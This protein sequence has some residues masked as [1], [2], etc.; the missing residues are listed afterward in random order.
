MFFFLKNIKKLQNSYKMNNKRFNF[1]K[2]KN[3]YGSVRASFDDK[4]F[5]LLILTYVCNRESSYISNTGL[6]S[7]FIW[8]QFSHRICGIFFDIW[9]QDMQIPSVWYD[10]EK[11]MTND[12]SS[13]SEVCE[14]YELS[15]FIQHVFHAVIMSN[16]NALT[17][18]IRKLDNRTG[19][20]W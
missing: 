3:Y 13:S 10:I 7:R 5:V 16:L 9:K 2:K 6:F 11:I 18:M 12:S 19:N 17:F 8:F 15:V 14:T 20:W 1:E 4:T